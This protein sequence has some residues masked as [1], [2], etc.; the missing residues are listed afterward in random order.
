MG[1]YVDPPAHAVVLPLNKKDQIQALER[2]HPDLP[3]APGHPA[4][5]THDYTRRPN[6]T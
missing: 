1:L 6:T 4:A 2:T 5:Q 3:L